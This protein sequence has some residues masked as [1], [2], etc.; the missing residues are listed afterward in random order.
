MY[1]IYQIVVKDKD[2]NKTFNDWSFIGHYLYNETLFVIRNL[3]TGLDKDY[4]KVTDNERFVI[5]DVI[6]AFYLYD[7][8]NSIGTRNKVPSYKFLNYYFAVYKNSENY[9]Y[10]PKH[11]AQYIIKLA[12]G[13]FRNWLK[14]IREYKINP[15]KFAGKPKIPGY[16]KESTTFGISNQEA[17]IKKKKNS[18][19][20]K[21]PSKEKY[22]PMYVSLNI[23]LKG[24]RLKEVTVNKYYGYNKITLIA[25][26]IIGFTP[27]EKDKSVKAGLDFGVNNI[28]A[29]STNTG[30]SLLV[31]GNV[32]KSKNQWFNKMIAKNLRG[33]TIGTDNKA[34]SSKA[35][36]K[37]Y[38][39]RNNY[40]RDMLHKIAK[41]VIYWCVNNDVGVLVLGR[42]KYWKQKVNIGKANNQNFVQIPIYILIGYIKDKAYVNG[43]EVI[44][45]EESYTS[46]SSFLD[47]DYL[48]VYKK[49]D[50]TNHVF[51]GTRA[52]RGLYKTKNKTIINADLNGACNIL[53][54]RFPDEDFE[55]E[56]IKYLQS[57]EVYRMDKL[58]A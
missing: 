54:K 34:V 37:I 5:E 20:L 38:M 27:L 32:I 25:E 28:V 41:K 43:I 31:K 12:L 9:R 45:Q 48:P 36:Q 53:R 22:K 24:K 30:K 21:L 46:K 56:N 47:M 6:K 52:S 19:E 14:A 50:D 26:N 39:K 49:N 8:P 35:L 57:P 18:W 1:S 11:T 13:N 33:Q 7:S 42:S 23:D 17:T 40:M 16:K 58:V 15:S 44:E 10:L 29:I 3:F 2:I 55:L 51:S 4:N